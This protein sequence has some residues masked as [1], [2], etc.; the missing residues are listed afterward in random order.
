MKYKD[1][2]VEEQA[3]ELE[4]N[5]ET[6][7]ALV[8][9]IQMK[10]MPGGTYEVPC[11]INGLPLKF[12]F[13]T[14]ASD[15]TL[16]SVEANFMLKNDYLSEKDFRGARRYL[17]ADGTIANGAI[18]RIK[19]VKVGDVTLKNI[20]ASVVNNQKAPLLL[21]QSVLNRFGTITVDNEK[22]ILTIKYK[23]RDR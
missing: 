17:T 8:S 23:N 16:S 19:E 10:K 2:P 6:A 22:L 14:G 21:G 12:I 4:I 13:D 1:K 7:E 9:E 15:V 11:T 3:E 5:I 20:E 18:V